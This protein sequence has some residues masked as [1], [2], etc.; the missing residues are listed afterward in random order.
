MLT[1]INTT[2]GVKGNGSQLLLTRV[3]TG[4]TGAI[5]VAAESTKY[6]ALVFSAGGVGYDGVGVATDP[7]TSGLT[8]TLSVSSMTCKFIIKY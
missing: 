4:Q 3:S 6:A 1:W 5:H 8:G 2:V 7:N